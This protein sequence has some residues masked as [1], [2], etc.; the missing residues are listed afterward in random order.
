[1]RPKEIGME[2]SSITLVNI[3]LRFERQ[4]Q[5]QK[6]RTKVCSECL[7]QINSKRIAIFFGFC[8]LASFDK[9]HLKKNTQIFNLNFCFNNYSHRIV[10]IVY[11]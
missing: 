10:V 9:C 6:E 1:M 8:Y 3:I 4:T 11:E 5:V 7:L 2:S